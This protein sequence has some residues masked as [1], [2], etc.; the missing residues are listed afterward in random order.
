VRWRRAV[1]A[2]AQRG[3]IA[4]EERS[5]FRNYRQARQRVAIPPW[6]L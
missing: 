5:P 3:E 1:P 2:R 4:G 6:Y